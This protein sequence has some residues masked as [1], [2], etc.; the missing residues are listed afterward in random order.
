MKWPDSKREEKGQWKVK[1]VLLTKWSLWEIFATKYIWKTKQTFGKKGKGWAERKKKN[2]TRYRIEYKW[3]YV[4]LDLYSV[5][6][7]NLSWFHFS[8]KLKW[9][10]WVAF[11]FFVRLLNIFANLFSF[12]Y[13]LRRI[14]LVLINFAYGWILRCCFF[15]LSSF[16]C[17][18]HNMYHWIV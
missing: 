2:K 1:K 5:N 6:S 9:K 7:V 8:Q 18:V 4:D 12:F 16:T 3:K 15:N 10:L 11:C 13:A 17:P 14:R